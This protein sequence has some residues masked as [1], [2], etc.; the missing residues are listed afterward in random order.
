MTFDY[1]PKDERAKRRISGKK[2]RELLLAQNPHCAECGLDLVAMEERRRRALKACEDAFNE[3]TDRGVHPWTIERLLAVSR[4]NPVKIA[5][6]AMGF[7]KPHNHAA[8][9][10]HSRPLSF[11]GVDALS[12][13]RALCQPCHAEVTRQQAPKLASARRRAKR[14]GLA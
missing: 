1:A 10:D 7:R 2:A 9:V 12:G 13:M 4:H 14:R 8:E 3:A 6:K 11:G 5:L